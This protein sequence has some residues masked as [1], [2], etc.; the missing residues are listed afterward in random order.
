MDDEQNFV[1]P[2]IIKEIRGTKVGIFG[3]TSPEAYDS[4]KALLDN[5]T[6]EE[7]LPCSF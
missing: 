4:E 2:Y 1:T 5:I 6:I 3:L 7:P